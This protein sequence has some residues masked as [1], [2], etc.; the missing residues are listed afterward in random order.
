MNMKIRQSQHQTQKQILAPVMQQSIEMLLLPIGELDQTITQALQENPL[1]EVQEEAAK[2]SEQRDALDKLIQYKLRRSNDKSYLTAYESPNDEK[3]EEKQLSRSIT[4]EDHLL[5]QLHL[6]ISNPRERQ[7]GEQIIGGL[8]ADGYFSEQ[9]CEDIAFNLGFKNAKPVIE[10]L[11][12]IQHFDPVGIAS[13]NLKE[14]LLLQIPD[15]L[16]GKNSL[17]EK[18]VKDHLDD[19]CH[20]RFLGIAK[21][22]NIR[23]EEVK[24]ITKIISSLEPKPARRFSQITGEIYIKPDI[25][26]RKQENR[27]FVEVNHE[28]IPRLTISKTYRE[29]INDPKLTEHDR[30][31]INERIKNAAL[32]IKSIEQRGHTLQRIA[33]FIIE[34][35]REFLEKGHTFLKPMILKTVAKAL[36]RNESTISRAI[37]NKYMDTPQGLLAMKYFFSQAVMDEDNHAVSNRSIKETIKEIVA[38]ENKSKPLS[39]QKILE[40]LKEHNISIARRTIGKYREELRILPAHLRKQ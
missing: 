37:N 17:A 20:K 26:I 15:R 11:K 2:T 38:Q 12:R 25:T 32:F 21:K 39:D 33:E 22:M 34:R 19:L 4:L 1:L 29:L 14:C 35:Q 27:Y 36:D 16:N 8:D 10:V 6:E 30:E 9:G 7:I 5:Q 23:I 31:F 3:S 40:L 24:N 13:R 28:N 18:M